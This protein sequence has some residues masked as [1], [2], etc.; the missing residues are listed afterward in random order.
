MKIIQNNIFYLTI[1]FIIL[2]IILK[3]LMLPG[4]ISNLELFIVLL[5]NNLL[6]HHVYLIA[7]RHILITYNLNYPYNGRHMDRLVSPLI[8]YHTILKIH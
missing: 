7:I 6:P 3:F 8:L 2:D 4:T 5:R 1:I